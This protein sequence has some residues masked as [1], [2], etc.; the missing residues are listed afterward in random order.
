VLPLC[1]LLGLIGGQGVV[2]CHGNDGHRRIELAHA[3]DSC[4]VTVCEQGEEEG[5]HCRT[6]QPGSCEDESIVSV[7]PLERT[8]R[9]EI[10]VSAAADLAVGPQLGLRPDAPPP[11]FAPRPPPPDLVALHSVILRI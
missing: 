4:P 11:S 7:P 3:D 10:F 1:L 8:R 9:V 2:L 6:V 5:P